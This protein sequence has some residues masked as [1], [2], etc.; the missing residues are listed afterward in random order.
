V[1]ALM[2]A[3]VLAPAALVAAVAWD[4]LGELDARLLRGRQAAAEAAAERLDEELTADL[5][6]LQRIASTLSRDLDAP[7]PGREHEVLRR[8]YLDFRF[9]GGLFLLDAG[10]RLL[11][12]EPQ[13]P[14][15]LAPAPG[16][17][18]V[19][20][21]LRTGK[22][23]VSGLVRDGEGFRIYALVA[24]TGWRGEVTGAVAGLVDPA[25]PRQA[26]ALQHV[27]RGGAGHADLVDAEG[28]VLVSTDRSRVRGP[29]TCRPTA[30]RLIREHRARST[31]CGACHSG[32]RTE[33]VLAF[34]PLAAA[35]WGVSLVEPEREVLATSGALPAGAAAVVVAVL[36]AAGFFAWGAA[37][38]VTR[39]VEV[40]TSAAEHIAAGHLGE[41]IPD[42]GEDEVGR[43]GRSL[44]R[45][46]TSI[47]ELLGA[48]EHARADLE[49]R[50][51]ERTRELAAALQELREREE[52]RARALRLVLTAQEDERRRIARELHD[53]TTQSLAVLVMGLE[54][55]V[56]ALRTGGPV[57]RLDEA[58]ALAVHALEEVHRIIRDLRPSVLDDLG[59]FSA[60]RWSAESLLQDRGVAVRCELGQAPPGRLPP[61][62]EIAVFR[63]CQEALNN[64]PA[65]P[66]R[67]GAGAAGDR[68]KP[69]PGGRGRRPGFDAMRRRRC[70]AAHGLL[71]IASAPSGRRRA[72]IESAPGGDW[73]V[74]E[75]PVG[76]PATPPAPGD[77]AAAPGDNRP[78]E[79]S[80]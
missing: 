22:P 36:L 80:G 27:V 9:V 66:G 37:R 54:S 28:T 38:S 42:L 20:D 64:R 35:P 26:A 69:A 25:L 73:V 65:R 6:V 46:R 60:V 43:L 31:T 62:V 72:R 74:V 17:P 75:V 29:A 77:S 56:Q 49:G 33:A 71:G 70:A 8:A 59:L 63:I 67:V 53:D 12:E 34:A 41:P 13:R 24:V 57:P 51:E 14:R 7:D 15:S 52:Q 16:L 45:M 39:P 40:L 11:V 47:G 76:G 3:G 30:T 78:G 79:R 18:A 55:A 58:K 61:E 44:D 10:G 32:R 50:V 1:L 21:A 5:E 68:R 23:Q 4:R 48:V 2:A 19:A